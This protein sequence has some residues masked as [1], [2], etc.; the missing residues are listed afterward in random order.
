MNIVH[1]KSF[2]GI[3]FRNMGHEEDQAPK[4]AIRE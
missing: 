2:W 3:M 4:K 1:L